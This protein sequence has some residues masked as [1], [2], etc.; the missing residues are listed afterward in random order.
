M[1]LGFSFIR[2]YDVFEL[3]TKRVI[4]KC[5]HSER[6]KKLAENVGKMFHRPTKVNV[7]SS[8]Q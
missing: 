2:T 1:W 8:Q 3:I 5:V 4:A 6:T 7:E